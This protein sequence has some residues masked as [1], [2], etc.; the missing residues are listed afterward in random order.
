MGYRSVNPTTGEIVKAYDNHR[1]AEIES[2]LTAAYGV[3][4]SQ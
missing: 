3:Y 2:A 1:D 4:Q